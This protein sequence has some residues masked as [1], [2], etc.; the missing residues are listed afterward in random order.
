[1]KIEIKFRKA[2]ALLRRELLRVAVA[3]KYHK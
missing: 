3:E 1:M 2:E